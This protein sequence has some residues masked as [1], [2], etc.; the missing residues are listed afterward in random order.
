MDQIVTMLNQHAI[1]PGLRR[2]GRSGIGLFKPTNFKRHLAGGNWLKS[3]V[4]LALT[5]VEGGGTFQAGRG[6]TQSYL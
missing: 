3:R 5:N 4:D 2:G 1:L 6:R